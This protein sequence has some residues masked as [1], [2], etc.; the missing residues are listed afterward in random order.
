MNEE[1]INKKPN[2]MNLL[3]NG[4]EK[5]AYY[6]GVKMALLFGPLVINK[7]GEKYLYLV[8][9]DGKTSDIW[10]ALKD[11]DIIKMRQ[12]VETDRNELYASMLTEYTIAVSKKSE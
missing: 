1:K 11:K 6:N 2:I 8:S 9:T 7:K 5:Y 12:Y 4:E 3:E 10:E